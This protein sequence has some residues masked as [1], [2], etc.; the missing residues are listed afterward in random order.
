MNNYNPLPNE[1]KEFN[2]EFPT[3][4]KGSWEMKLIWILFIL[5]VIL[6]GYIKASSFI[7]S[8]RIS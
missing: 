2:K 6:I 3:S 7:R 5:V 1:A 4:R 8:K